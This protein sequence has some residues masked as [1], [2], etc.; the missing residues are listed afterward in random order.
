MACIWELVIELQ[1]E[2]L[3]KFVRVGTTHQRIITIKKRLGELD[4]IE[5]KVSDLTSERDEFDVAGLQ[6]KIEILERDVEYM[7]N[8]INNLDQRRGSPSPSSPPLGDESVK[9]LETLVTTSKVWSMT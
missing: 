5:F 7:L 2:S 3:G 1:L 4:G 8:R 6:Q 9:N